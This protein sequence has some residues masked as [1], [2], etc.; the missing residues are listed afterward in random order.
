QSLS[1]SLTLSDS[2]ST[3]RSA[4]KSLSNLLT[5]SDSMS[6]SSIQ[7]KSLSD[8]I[9]VTDSMSTSS[10]KTQSMSDSVSI[11]DSLTTSSSKFQSLT[12]SEIITDAIL[13]QKST[14]KSFNEIMGLSDSISTS[15][16][17]QIINLDALGMTDTAS[18]LKISS[19]QYLVPNN[20]TTVNVDP[21]KPNLIVAS[22]NAALSSITIP[23]SATSSTLSY[24]SI[25]SSG[26]V[27]ILHTLNITKDTNGDGHI[28][29][30]LTIPAVT[31]ISNSAWD[32]ILQLPTV[33]TS[34]SLVLPVPQGQVGTAKTV[35]GVGSSLPLTFNNATRI[36]FIGENGTHVGFFSSPT[37]VTEVTQTCTSDNQSVA[38]TLPSGGICKINVGNNLVVWTKHFTGFVTWTLSSIPPT[39]PSPQIP[40]ASG[41]G[42][43]TGAATPV[44]SGIT[45]AAGML[46]TGVTLYDVTY[47]ICDQ[48]KVQFTVGSPDS[49]TPTVE[50]ATPSGVVTAQISEHQP[51]AGLHDLTQKYVLSYDAP[52]KPGIKTFNMLITPATGTGYVTAKVDVTKCK[53]TVTFAPIPIIGQS[54]PDAPKIFDI[55][56]QIDNGTRIP[57]AETDNQY[58]TNQNVTISGLVYSPVPLDHAEIRVVKIGENTTIG[59][60]KV[61]ATVAPI[62]VSNTY[63]VSATLPHNYLVSPAITYWVYAKNIEGFEVESEQYSIGVSTPYAASGTIGFV[64]PQNVPAGL[65]QSPQVYFTNNSTG[66]LYGTV[67]LIVDGKQVS[68][69]VDHLFDKGTSVMELDWNVPDSDNTTEH[70]VQAV[71]TFYGQTFVSDK[72]EVNSYVYKK[73]TQLANMQPIQS[74]VDKQGNVIANPRSLYSSFVTSNGTLFHVVSPSGVCVI[75]ESSTCLVNES[76]LTASERYSVV[77]LDGANYTVYYSD[78]HSPLQRFTITSL[79]PITGDWKITLE[80]NGIEQKDMED[81]VRVNIKYVAEDKQ[82][83]ISLP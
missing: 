22:S 67:S 23:F 77:T 12:E 50:F 17:S 8:S 3:A 66:I 20:Q 54:S 2:V 71:A 70:S 11:V 10:I 5:M 72:A 39:P 15:T 35:I 16:S 80:K 81:K 30:V 49:T 27:H 40:S 75:G 26:T 46:Q 58:V 13:A 53:Q 62:S 32:G 4:T 51:Y 7:T 68:Q 59:Y 28:E 60:D 61:I 33:Q 38:N 18:L 73:I 9:L 65:T 31:D 82:L 55:K 14:L 64:I 36:S 69:F 43:G 37:S 24:A 19:N 52:L 83:L 25:V 42:Y 63:L 29:V 56:L 47:D 34:S 74:F 6:T 79:Q 78:I 76:T 57:A 41:G 45:S 1:D 21:S 44:A 48:Q